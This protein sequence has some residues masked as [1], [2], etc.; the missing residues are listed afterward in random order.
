[1]TKQPDPL[2][3]DVEV[4]IDLYGVSATRFGRNVAGDPSLLSK[5]REGRHI[6]KPDLRQRITDAIKR[7]EKG[8]TL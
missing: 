1:M 8:E 5:L 7:L 2:L 4:A 3:A 6:H